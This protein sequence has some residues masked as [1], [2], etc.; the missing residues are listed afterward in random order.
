MLDAPCSGSGTIRITDKGIS[1]AFSDKLLSNSVKLQKALLTKALTL[2]KAGGRLVYST[3]SV[4]PDENCGVLS[5]VLPR[6]NADVLP[7]SMDRFEGVPLLP[8]EIDGTVTVCPNGL[9]EGFFVAVI[10]KRP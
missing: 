1:G 8:S 9:Y 2:L 6:F 3:C 10:A 7:I 5:S 4:L